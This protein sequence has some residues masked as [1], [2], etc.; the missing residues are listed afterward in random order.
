MEKTLFILFKNT[1]V[2]ARQAFIRHDPPKIN[3]DEFVSA[4][5]GKFSARNWHQFIATD[6]GND[7][8]IAENGDVARPNYKSFAPLFYVV[9]YNKE[10]RRIISASCYPESSVERWTRIVGLRV[11]EKMPITCGF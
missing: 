5:G 1:A 7:E 3:E 2:D 4:G 9:R 6:I 8:F 10:T 11:G